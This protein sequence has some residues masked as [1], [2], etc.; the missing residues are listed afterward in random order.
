MRLAGKRALIT[1]AAN[2]IGRATVEAFIR[3]GAG[4]IATDIDPGV[5]EAWGDLGPGGRALRLDVMDPAAID[6]VARQVGS[7]D[8]LFNCA[9]TVQNGALLDCT[10]REWQFSFDLNVTAM[11]RM[12]RA[13]LPG[14]IAA[15]GGAIVNMASV[16]SSLKGVA[17]RCAYGASKAAVIGLTKSIATDYV[18]HN[19]RCNA[20]CPGTVETPSLRARAEALARA[21]GTDLDAALGAFRARQ[22][23]GR[24]GT[25]D[26]IAEAVVYLAS[27]AAAFVTGSTLVIDGGFIN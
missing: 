26:E 22:P 16:A 25:A 12:I 7:V 17:D 23:M 14:M 11:F 3:E 8:V 4:V 19:V 9:G 1:A 6:D 20:V 24:L 27:D 13:F 15:G 21:R 5:M 10:D 18:R 2:G